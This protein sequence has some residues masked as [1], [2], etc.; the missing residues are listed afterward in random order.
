[1]TLNIS[2]GPDFDAELPIQLELVRDDVVVI[3]DSE[4]KKVR[5]ELT[6]SENEISHVVS[7]STTVFLPV[8]HDK[9]HV[10]L[11]VGKP[12][13]KRTTTTPQGPARCRF[14]DTGR[15]HRGLRSSRSRPPKVREIGCIVWTVNSSH[16]LAVFAVS[17]SSVQKVD[18][19]ER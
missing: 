5:G 11:G 8:R 6:A 10:Q 14:K 17:K 19:L 16:Q 9:S 18:L 2:R 12:T 13:D 7:L 15:T 4:T 3:P 1:V